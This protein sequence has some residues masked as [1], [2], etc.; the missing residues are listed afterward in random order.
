MAEKTD[1]IKD[2]RLRIIWNSNSHF[3]WSGYGVFTRDLLFRLRDDGW[4]IAEIAF[5]GLQGHE[6]D[7]D[8]IHMYPVMADPYGSDALLNHSLDFKANVAFT[9]QDVWSLQPQ[10]LQGLIN[11]KI[12]WLPYL[13]IDQEPAQ[14]AV[15]QKLN[16]AYKIITFS[17]FGQRVLSD[18]GYSSKLIVEGTDTNIFKP[19]DKI[20]L[21]EKLKLPQDMFLFCMIAANKE[22]PPRKGFQ[23]ALEAFKLFH[24]NHP[25]SGIFFHTQQLSPTGFPIQGYANH[26]GLAKNVFFLNQY[27]ATFKA[28]SNNIVEEI[29]A[30]DV[31]LHPSMTEGFGLLVIEGQACGKPVIINDCTS[32]PELVIKDKTG[33]ICK[34]GKAWWK[35]SGGYAHFADVESLHEQ[36]EKVYKALSK[37]NTI[38]QDARENVVKNYN[39]D[40]LFKEQWIPFLEQLQTDLLGVDLK[41]KKE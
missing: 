9:M 28:D 14:D 35:H 19:M 20:P 12:H 26:L 40:M 10:D 29:N 39:I 6:L 5:W 21:R 30:S 34:T 8:G 32:M 31:V 41:E 1:S 37:P 33:W 25:N 15:L 16:Y 38:A 23:E 36:M 4:T 2:R 11:N 24:D 27:V 13:P 17:K 7:A 22:N 3:S 18:H